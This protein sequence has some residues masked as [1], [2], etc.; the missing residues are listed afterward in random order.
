VGGKSRDL[1]TSPVVIS[2]VWCLWKGECMMNL[3]TTL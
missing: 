3:Q 1:V 2:L